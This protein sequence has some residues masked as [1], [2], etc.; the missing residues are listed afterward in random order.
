MQYLDLLVILEF[1]F[2]F[3]SSVV[4]SYVQQQP[5]APLIRGGLLLPYRYFLVDMSGTEASQHCSLRQHILASCDFTDVFSRPSSS[6]AG[7]GGSVSVA[8]IG[9][10]KG[11]WVVYPARNEP[12]RGKLVTVLRKCSRQCGLV[13]LREGSCPTFGNLNIRIQ[14]LMHKFC[15]L[16]SLLGRTH[17]TRVGPSSLA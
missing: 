9:L 8:D 17:S 3:A 13:V 12:R 6:A 4:F 7:G 10:W 2:R 11:D 15:S 14:W 16:S 5:K 1:F